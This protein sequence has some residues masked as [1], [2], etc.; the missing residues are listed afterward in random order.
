M[1]FFYFGIRRAHYKWYTAN[2]AE[3]IRMIATGIFTVG[4]IFITY[5]QCDA[6][7]KEFFQKDVENEVIISEINP[8]EM[9]TKIREMMLHAW[10][11]YAQVV[12]GT[13][14][15]RAISG[16]VH[17]GS[18]FG[19]YKL[20]ATIIESLDTL[21]LMGL[22][23]ELKRSRDWIDKSFT[24]DRVDEP[25]SVFVLTSRLLCPMLTLYSLTGDPFY[26]EKAIHIADKILPAFDT[27]TGIPR[28]LV[29]PKEGSTLTKYLDDV[30]LTSEFG[31]LHLEFFYLSEITG[32]SV[33]KDRVEGIRKRL[34]KANNLNG[35]YPNAFCTKYGKWENQNCS[36]NRYHD[37]LLKSWVQSGKVDLENADQFKED[38]L[39]VA[40]NLV[41]INP[42]GVTYVSELIGSTLTHRMK[43][44]DCFAGGLFVLG[45]AEAM[46]KHWEKY[47]QI[48]IGIT[49]TCHDMFYDS[50]TQLGPDSFA[51]TKESQEEISTLQRNFY[52]LRPEVV[53]SYLVLWRL[54]HHPKYRKWGVE[55]ILA[56]EKYCRTPNGY[57]GI[58]D[59]HNRS[60]E[61]DDVQRTFFLGA[62]LKYLFLL[63]SDDGVI[64]LEEWVFN[65]AGHFLPIKGVN[66]MYREYKINN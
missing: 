21:H 43:Q 36:M 12:W 48:G 64:S 5:I 34:A 4:V 60:S 2:S 25:L 29:V 53:E 13:N 62:T 50:S 11:N 59:V 42:E 10:R 54:T 31:A 56:I 41:V 7:V 8:S 30:S 63:F 38:L 65:S 52:M 26:K 28:R 27:S 37:I 19:S 3:R 18:D 44:S 55:M 22:E 14:E 61:P 15:F 1:H 20:G 33:Y 46:M 6:M 16:R 32:N 51:F 45:A 23:K 58:M 57:T 47:A 17:V 49:E 35:L 40:Q 24:L 39:A 9:R 66:A